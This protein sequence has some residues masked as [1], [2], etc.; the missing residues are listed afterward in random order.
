MCVSARLRECP[1]G[2]LSADGCT[3]EAIE[4]QPPTCGKGCE[5]AY[6]GECRCESTASM[7]QTNLINVNVKISF[8]LCLVECFSHNGY[9]EDYSYVVGTVE[10][11]CHNPL[12]E[13]SYRD[14]KGV[15]QR[16]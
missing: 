1:E 3:C 2:R 7:S 4:T 5:L 10:D 8:F 6:D 12:Q 9:C 11:C 15:C 16:W 14:A 13:R